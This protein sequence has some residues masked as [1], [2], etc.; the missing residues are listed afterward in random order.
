MAAEC[1]RSLPVAPPGWPQ[2]AAS[3]SAGRCSVLRLPRFLKCHLC[4]MAALISC[5]RKKHT[6][7]VSGYICSQG[8]VLTHAHS[9]GVIRHRRV[10]WQSAGAAVQTMR[11]GGEKKT[12]AAPKNKNSKWTNYLAKIRIC[13]QRQSP[14]CDKAALS[15]E[16][17]LKQHPSC[18]RLA[19][20][21][22]GGG[23]TLRVS[24]SLP[25]LA[26]VDAAREC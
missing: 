22:R 24:H 17:N 11:N 14:C 26:L 23:A 18:R 8:S 25:R 7:V 2:A 19:G 9:V 15:G 21:T 20:A 3:V 13:S 1:G 4:L 12:A 6:P 5:I 16:A 10:S